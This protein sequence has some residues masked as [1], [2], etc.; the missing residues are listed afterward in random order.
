MRPVVEVPWLVVV[1]GALGVVIFVLAFWVALL[2][3]VAPFA[4]GVALYS[5]LLGGDDA[6]LRRR[7]RKAKPSAFEDVRPPF[8]LH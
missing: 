1:V 7:R 2:Y 3:V 5:L 4:L 6:P 8:R